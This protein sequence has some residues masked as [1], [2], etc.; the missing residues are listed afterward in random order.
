VLNSISFFEKA[1]PILETHDQISLYLDR[2]QAGLELTKHALSLN[3][4]YRDASSLYENHK[5]LNEWL[6][7]NEKSFRKLLKLKRGISPN[8]SL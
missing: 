7:A 8:E 1:R 5:D 3:F 6:V 2:D 4:Q